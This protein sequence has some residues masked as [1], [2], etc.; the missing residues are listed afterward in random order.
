MTEHDPASYPKTAACACGALTVTVTAP[1]QMVHACACG[2]CQRGTG[3]AFSYSAFF[4]QSAVN[5]RGEH[6][7]WRRSSDAGR[8]SESSFCPT[9]G[10]TVFTRLEAL[11]DVVCV[12][13][14]CFNDPDFP[15]PGR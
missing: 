4:P 14:G 2:E 9:C 12:S 8:W 13:A 10:V 6:K 7:V 3:S 15:K 5:I 1:P 11:P